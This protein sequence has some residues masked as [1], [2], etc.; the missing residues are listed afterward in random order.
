VTSLVSYARCP[1]QFYWSVI[2]PLPRRP[3][4]AARIGV[5]VHRRIELRA[6]RQLRLLEPD[7]E[8]SI[9]PGEWGGEVTPSTAA[10]L[11]ASFMLSPFADL[12]PVRVEAPFVLAVGGRLVRGRV[13][14]V[15]SRDGKV[16]LV[17]FKT[18]R[19][20]ATGDGGATTQLE[21]YALAAAQAWREDPASLRTTFC[22]LRADGPAELDSSD[23]DA[24]RLDAV[25]RQL[26]A[27][28]SRLPSEGFAAVPGAWCQRCDFAEVCPAGRQSIFA[29]QP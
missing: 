14:A 22:Y 16:E 20:P 25:K 27:A 9:T 26:E 17:D 12:D 1:R 23:W 5:E 24:G 18:G 29:A 8:A 3:S 13:D 2:R 11:E 10:A 19:R 6:N 28:L 4:P 21:L 7:P 15:Y